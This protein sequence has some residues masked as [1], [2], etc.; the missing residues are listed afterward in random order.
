MDDRPRRR[1]RALLA[2]ALAA[3]LTLP[4]AGPAAQAD[5]VKKF[6]RYGKDVREHRWWTHAKKRRRHL[7]WHRQHPEATWK[8]HRALHHGDLVH[9]HRSQHRFRVLARQRGLASWYSG[10]V[11]ACGV[12]LKGLYAAHRTWPCGTRVSVRRGS[13]YVVVRILDRGPHVAGRVVDL[14]PGAFDRLGSLGEGVMGVTIYR[15]QRP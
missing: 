6:W 14:S 4:V 15:L 2:A 3:A 8:E 1:R 11:G 5:P 10:A 7:R 9:R 12:A 13:R